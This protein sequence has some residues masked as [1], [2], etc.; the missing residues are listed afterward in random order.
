[1]PKSFKLILPVPE[2]SNPVAL[3]LSLDHVESVPWRLAVHPRYRKLLVRAYRTKCILF[4][5]FAM[6]SNILRRIV[7]ISA[8]DCPPG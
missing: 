6:E 3:T 7:Y 5:R 1:M 8:S 2:V 4:G